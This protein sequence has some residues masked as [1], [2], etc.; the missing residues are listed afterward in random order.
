MYTANDQ[1][2]VV[3]NA[4]QEQY[5]SVAALSDG[6][7]VVTWGS[8]GQDG[9]GYGVYG[10]RYNANGTK[11]GSEFQVNT[12]F[13]HNQL[14]PLVSGFSDGG[15]VVVWESNGQDG[16]GYGVYGQ[17][18]NANGTKNG[19]EFQ[20]NTATSG[21]QNASSVAALSGGLF[22]V[23]WTSMIQGTDS[24][25]LRGRVFS[26][27][28]AVG[29][30][31]SVGN[32]E[33][34]WGY[35]KP[36]TRLSNGKVVS[37]SKH[38][39]S[40]TAAIFAYIYSV[41]GTN[42]ATLERS[43]Q[44]KRDGTSIGISG[45]TTDDLNYEEPSVAAL[46]GG[47][48]VVVWYAN[49]RKVYGQRYNANGDT[50]GN[51]FVVGT[52]A[53]L[54]LTDSDNLTQPIVAGL[55]DG[56]FVVTWTVTPGSLNREVVGQIFDQSA[57]KVG[58]QLAVNGTNGTLDD[59]QNG[60]LGLAGLTNGGFVAAW[61]SDTSGAGAWD[62]YGR[63][64]TSST[65]NSAPTAVTLQNTTA[66][67]AENTS[68]TTRIK[69]ADIAITDDGLGTNT[70]SLSGADAGSFEVASGFLYLKAG[71]TLDYETK[72]SYNVTV[73][74]DDTTVGATP[75]LTTNFTLNV[76]D[77]NEAPTGTNT[78]PTATLQ[79]IIT[80]IATDT[81]TTNRIKVAEIN[82]TDDGVGTNN[83]TLTGTDAGSFE[84]DGTSLY[85]KA[86]V[87]LAVKNYKVTVNVND[88][89]V[90]NTPDWTEELTLEAKVNAAPTAIALH[91][92]IRENTSTKERI[93]LA[94]IDITDD[95]V[96]TNDITLTGTD[97]GSFEVDNNFLYVRE[98]VDLDYET[99]KKIYTVTVKVKDPNVNGSPEH[100]SNFSLVVTDEIYDVLLSDKTGTTT[101]LGGKATFN[102]S[103]QT[104]PT[105]DVTIR[106]RALDT[107]EGRLSKSALTFTPSNWNTHQTLEVTGL[108]DSIDDG[109][110]TYSITSTV[111]SRDPNYNLI[112]ASSLTITN[113]DNDTAGITTNT[114]TGITT[115]QKSTHFDFVLNSQPTHNVTIDFTNNGG[116]Q[117]TLSKKSLQFTPSNWNRTQTLEV[118][119][120][121][122]A[123]DTTYNITSKV[124]SDDGKY[125]DM[126]VLPLSIT[127]KPT[128]TAG[129]T[130]TPTTTGTTTEAGGKASFDFT[131]NSQPTQNVTISFS[132]VNTREGRLS[133]PS[134]TFTPI[135]WNRPQTL[136]VIGVDDRVRDG[137]IPY[138]ITPR[139]T[140]KDPAY[141]VVSVLP[142]TITNTD[143][144]TAGITV[145]STTGT[146]TKTG[147]T[148]SFELTLNTQ[149]TSNVKIDFTE[150]N[151]KG[152]LST[153]SLTFTAKNW[154]RPQ[155]V[156]VTGKGSSSD[157]PYNITSTVTSGDSNYTSITPLTLTITNK[158]ST[159][160]GTVN[161]DY[162]GAGTG[163]HTLTGGGGGDTLTGG[164]GADTFVY[165]GL[166]DSLLESRDILVN[167]SQ[168]QGDRFQLTPRPDALFNYGLSRARTIEAALS[169]AYADTDGNDRPLGDKEAVFFTWNRQLYL[170]VNDSTPGFQKN[171]DLLLQ[172]DNFTWLAGDNNPAATLTVGNY[173]A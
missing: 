69:V 9:S 153:N 73:N 1:L 145:N 139:I 149:P 70:I 19:G 110:R 136:E 147:G 140:S 45:E 104:Q 169:A 118:T 64:Y 96:G 91:V 120:K 99:D 138:T 148:A 131:L 2:T 13:N 112:R 10:Q 3:N 162:L 8:N 171:S 134:L 51:A 79:Q 144:D 68:T 150:D 95:G 32:N 15:F 156:T 132:G 4:R 62:V 53:N 83:I 6:G 59:K 152:S 11:N 66:T 21:H 129:I 84:V 42:G 94:Q 117:G 26:A 102:F 50:N 154:N 160:T 170:S 173:F 18:Y 146:T 46:S 119:G 90:G 34:Q 93:R 97:A 155:T 86:N 105:S 44:V 22:M 56:G 41:D 111:T 38:A 109:D 130:V 63:I 74:V 168:P 115:P 30:E 167:F 78:P 67:I 166:T 54:G 12:Y 103:L 29:S 33:A 124:T 80:A 76:S 142:L 135:T 75:D 16:S 101:E 35:E 39:V 164:N 23:T 17:R 163:N 24:C 72:A 14:D 128:L 106:F 71:T 60:K 43:I 52:G 133:R 141:Q 37:V 126:P 61:T 89:T 172:L 58:G 31:V 55:N 20:V 57:N 25:S 113:E 85:L 125:R 49:N 36:L 114:T 65:P 5:P 28:G 121:D 47:G 157:T 107:T 137:D 143:N 165:E 92:P 127:N 158:D 98:N 116:D 77:V 7:F 82:I 108:N 122:N 81:N 27:S 48:F 123:N 87:T 88:P 161:D 100:T 151:T 159:L 40:N